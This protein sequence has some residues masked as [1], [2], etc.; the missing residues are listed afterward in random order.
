[1]WKALLAKGMSRSIVRAER[2]NVSLRA[3]LL[4]RAPALSFFIFIFER[5]VRLFTT[6]QELLKPFDSIIEG[7]KVSKAASWR[8]PRGTKKARH[9]KDGGPT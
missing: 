1:M 8:G 6:S 9:L 7:K 5:V 4:F 3:L 2:I